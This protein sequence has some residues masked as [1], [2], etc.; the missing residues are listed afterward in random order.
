MRKRRKRC[1]QILRNQRPYNSKCNMNREIMM[2]R[3]CQITTMTRKSL[4]MTTTSIITLM[5]VKAMEMMTLVLTMMVVCAGIF[6]LY[7]V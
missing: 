7:G 1:G 3:S 6:D 4:E 5:L 2:M